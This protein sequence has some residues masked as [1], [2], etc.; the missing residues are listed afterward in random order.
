MEYPY[1]TLAGL[2]SGSISLITAAWSKAGLTNPVPA[3]PGSNPYVKTTFQSVSNGASPMMT[4]ITDNTAP[5]YNGNPQ[6]ANQYDWV[7]YS[8]VNGLAKDADSGIEQPITGLPSNPMR[9]TSNTYYL[10]PGS[11]SSSST[12]YWNPGAPPLLN[13]KTSTLVKDGSG[14]TAPTAQAYSEFVYDN[15][16]STGNVLQSWSWDSTK[17]SSA[18]A[19]MASGAGAG[20]LNSSNAIGISRTYLSGDV[21][22][23]T[24]PRGIERSFAYSSSG[25]CAP[26]PSDLYEAYG[27]ADQ[28]HW[29]FGWDCYTGLRTSETDADN[30]ITTS[31][32]YD[33]IGRQ[34][35]VNRQNG[36]ETNTAYNDTAQ[37]V[38]SRVDLNSPG[39]GLV[40]TAKSLDD[41]WRTYQTQETGDTCAQITTQSFQ[42][43]GSGNTYQVV[44]NPY[45]TTADPTMGW[46]LTTADTMGRV[47]SVGHYGSAIPAP[48]GSGSSSG[49]ATTSYNASTT[50][51]YGSSTAG[52][53][54]LVTDEAGV[55]RTMTSDGLGRL[56]QVADGLR[57]RP[58]TATP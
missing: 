10:V 6:T 3:Y 47:I 13:A 22:T 23:E 20:N 8:F 14:L 26:Y 41:L 15:G 42:R 19:Q 43:T 46:T 21:L 27:T 7:N 16:T 45:C 53:T 1:L 55:F 58:C 24:D 29:Q 25:G 57:R 5:D 4:A 51:G 50:G 31:A 44:S 40:Q 56:S 9:T 38:T 17:A 39:D 48:W 35:L 34:T 49:I 12:S 32:S 37:T 54:S 18:P 28:R 36:Q 11:A 52:G 30:S 2:F 33:V